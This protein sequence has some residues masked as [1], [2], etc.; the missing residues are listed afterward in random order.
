MPLFAILRLLFAYKVAGR[1]SQKKNQANEWRKLQKHTLSKACR[2]ASLTLGSAVFT[3]FEIIKKGKKHYSIL[4][5]ISQSPVLSFSLYWL[6]IK[7]NKK[8][9]LSFNN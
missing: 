5:R 3:N 9:A 2:F 6:C 4:E 8:Q 7:K 1:N